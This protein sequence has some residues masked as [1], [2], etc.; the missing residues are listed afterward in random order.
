MPFEVPVGG[1]SALDVVALDFLLAA[2]AS[3]VLFLLR[4]CFAPSTF[5]CTKAPSPASARGGAETAGGAAASDE[6]A[7]SGTGTAAAAA[8]AESEANPSGTAD[9]TAVT[10]AR[11]DRLHFLHLHFAAPA[12]RLGR[13]TSLKVGM[14]AMSLH[15]NTC[16]VKAAKPWV[17]SQFFSDQASSKEHEPGGPAPYLAS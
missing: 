7:G 11:L 10:A 15:R 4:L 9:A 12:P 8:A 1:W 14:V 3:L 16:M 17:M 6:M 2:V 13:R 5:G